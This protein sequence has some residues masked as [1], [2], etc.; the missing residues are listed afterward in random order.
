MT[1][2]DTPPAN[3]QKIV[4][5]IPAPPMVDEVEIMKHYVCDANCRTCHGRGR[6]GINRILNKEGGSFYQL[7]LCH[8]AVHKESEYAR[9]EKLLLEQFR[10]MQMAD[11]EIFR[12]LYRHSFFG[13]LK[14]GVGG[15]R[16]KIKKQWAVL[17]S[18][19]KKTF[20]RKKVADPFVEPASI[21]IPADE[22]V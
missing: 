13:G 18:Y 5:Q 4:G 1:Q 20:S 12:T 22:K 2:I 11:M 16:M 10:S 19:L 7:Q 14:Y 21:S 17:N 15:L 8:C 9:L 6:L 3:D